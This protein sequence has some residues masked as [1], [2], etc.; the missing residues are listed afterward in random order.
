LTSLCEQVACNKNRYST[1]VREQKYEP[2]LLREAIAAALQCERLDLYDKMVQW[3][4]E[5][6]SLETF[7]LLGR[8]MGRNVNPE[9]LARYEEEI[10]LYT[11]ILGSRG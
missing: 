10:R 4:R 7:R 11:V 5:P 6:V 1:D 2:V 9:S 3:V 8:I